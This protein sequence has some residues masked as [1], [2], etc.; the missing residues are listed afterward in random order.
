[1]DY[2]STG[3]HLVE[4]PSTAVIDNLLAFVINNPTLALLEF[5]NVIVRR[6][7]V[8]NEG[9]RIIGGGGAGHDPAYA[10]YVGKGMLNA[11]IHGSCLLYLHYRSSISYVC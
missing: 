3:Q 5:G 10:G 7:Y 9:V 4:D 2:F 6:D 8:T 11:A 1:M